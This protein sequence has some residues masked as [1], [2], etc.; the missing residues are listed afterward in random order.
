[1]L[2]AYG[3]LRRPGG[4]LG[5]KIHLPGYFFRLS[6]ASG[7]SICRTLIPPCTENAILEYSYGKW[8]TISSL[9]NS[10]TANLS[11]WFLLN[12][13]QARVILQQMAPISSFPVL[14]L[15]IKY[16]VTTLRMNKTKHSCCTVRK[17]YWEMDSR[18]G[19]EWKIL[20]RLK[21]P[22]KDEITDFHTVLLQS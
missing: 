4:L 3:R 9:F 13:L 6:R 17:F 21:M 19:Q 7:P 1:M 8:Q 5:E 2:Y 12:S 14:N 11:N 22:E 20:V 10:L 18:N 15:L 16:Q